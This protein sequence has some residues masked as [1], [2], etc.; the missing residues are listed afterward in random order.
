MRPK[1]A[2]K[3]LEKV[4]SALK[5]LRRWECWHDR[6]LGEE[7]SQGRLLQSSD[8]H[9]IRD[10]AKLDGAAFESWVSQQKIVRSGKVKIWSIFESISQAFPHCFKQSSCDPNELY[11]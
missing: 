8:L 3:T 1:N 2:T 10:H 4:L 9:S 7:F 5:H 6:D 11:R